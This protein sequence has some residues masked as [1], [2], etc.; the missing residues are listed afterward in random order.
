M[1]AERTGVFPNHILRDETGELLI[2]DSSIS[3]FDLVSGTLLQAFGD[4]GKKEEGNWTLSIQ[5]P[6]EYISSISIFETLGKPYH[7]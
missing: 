7:C 5:I 4:G 6:F 1:L 2:P 3:E